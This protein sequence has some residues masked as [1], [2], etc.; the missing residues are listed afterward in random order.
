[1]IDRAISLRYAKALFDS[2]GTLLGDF[3]SI[4]KIFNDHPKLVKFLKTPQ[5]S[6]I[7]KKKVLRNVL[8]MDS[9]F[10][11]FIFTLIQKGR[12]DSLQSIAHE[13]KLMAN[14]YLGVWEVD[15]VSAVPLDAPF[16]EKLKEKLEKDFCKKIKLNTKVNPKVL[17]GAI[18]LIEN[19]MLDWS[20]ESRLRKLKERLMRVS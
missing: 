17:G 10:L 15:I 14:E 4:I 16:E 9:L 12:I 13:Y 18:L 3:E 7:E 5:I 20:V 1:M 19:E 8:K 2:K 6:L 11:N